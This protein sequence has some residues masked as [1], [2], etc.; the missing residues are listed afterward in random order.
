MKKQ[1]FCIF[2]LFLIAFTFFSI[3]SS[4]NAQ[5]NSYKISGVVKDESGE[6][7]IG[8]TVN[9]KGTQISAMTD[10]NGNF[11]LTIPQEK[12]LLL[13]SFI[14][15]NP[16]ETKIIPNSSNY[17][18]VLKSNQQQLGE[19]VVTALGIKR[20]ERGLGF[21]TETLS[22]EA[23]TDARSNNWAT[24]L[25]GKVA[26][27]NI[28]SAGGG[29]LGTS[30]ITLRGDKSL[31]QDANGALIVLDG[32]PIGGSATGT[33][34][35]SYGAGSGS[36]IP[37]DFGDAINDINPDDIESITVLKGPSAAALYGS[38]GSNGAIIVTTKS[39]SKN[40]KGIG[41]SFSS[42]FSIDNVLK[43]PDYQ[44]EYGQGVQQKDKNGNW[45]YSYGASEDG[46]NTGS[47]SSAFGPKFDGQMYFQY[48]PTV[49]GQSLERQEWKAYKNNIKDFW[50]TGT[51]VRNSISVDGATDRSSFRISLSHQANKWMMPNT[52]FDRTSFATSYNYKVTN[53]L[54]FSTK[55]NFT[56]RSSDNLPGTG[57]NNQSI[58]YFMIFQNPNIDLSW[59]RPIWKTGSYQLEQIH[60]FSSYIDNPYLIAYEMVNPSDK[61]TLIGSV[62]GTYEF[63]RKFELIARTGLEM[64]HENREQH[65]PYNTANYPKGYYREDDIN[66]MEINTDFLFTYR[67]QLTQDIGF[68]ASAGGNIRKTEYRSKSGRVIGLVTP[69]VYKLSNALGSPL[70]SSTTKKKQVNSLYGSVNLNYGK[71]LFL[72][73]TGRNDWSSTLPVQNNSFF[74]P[75]TSLSGIISDMV[76]LPEQ[77]SFLK[78]RASWAE[79][80]N[81]T[82]PY[83][84][85][86]YYES[87][88]FSG[89]SKMP[90]TLHNA[91]LEPEI[92]RSY[93]A[94]IDFRMF[95]NRLTLDLTGYDNNTK[96]Q[97]IEVPLDPTTGYS[98][99]FINAGKIQN[100]G[101][102][103]L[104]SGIPIENKDFKWK[105]STNWSKNWNKVLELSEDLGD[106]EYQQ[107]ASSGTVYF[108]ARK[109]GSLGDMYGYKLLRNPEG[110]VIYDA[111]RGLPARPTDVEYVGNAYAKWKAGI[112]NEFTIKNF[113]ISFSFDGQYGGLVYSQSHH[114]MTEQ[115]KLQHTLYGRDSEDGMLV[116]DGVIDNGDGTYSPNTIR[117]LVS[118]YYADYYRRANVETNSFDATFIKLRDA[119]IEYN[120]PKSI[121]GKLKINS[122]S[123]AIFGRNIWMWTKEYPLFDPEAA[124]LNSSSIVP[125]VEM[126]Q[127][128]SSRTIG[129]NLNVKF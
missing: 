33:D 2:K 84:T 63:S 111:K 24:A 5:N 16:T 73:I 117:V 18:I 125:G 20:E 71:I 128:P 87:T 8:A 56:N 123:L 79:V 94:G 7:L 3:L 85:S 86:K 81:D 83:R 97:I 31:I 120:F 112:Q 55:I 44:Y 54:R 67:D 88:D 121:T 75:S 104:L 46:I 45:Y 50:R 34:S 12:G 124:A 93:E 13:T 36:D 122:L 78:L 126:G 30:R 76:E 127:L 110:K 68:R 42:S 22:G 57:Y 39:G 118:Q 115:G 23:L 90:T 101:L 47:T 26:G 10:I 119:R 15:Y 11:T 100:K 96:N 60:P 6:M 52:G 102:E 99:A 77:I 29:P 19:V 62:N 41:V 72:D 59:Y 129:I 1:T 53:K 38:R 40:K 14:G 70:L 35:N 106:D 25:S 74:Y 61:N 95:G 92:S 28:L 9:F 116:G 4:T 113:R 103:L 91:D 80:G 82:E 51:D 49:E 32:V 64:S 69:G 109:G 107:V 105:V 17:V 48:D 21:T 108:Y 65:R 114:K 43:W 37:I 66:Y 89:S 27:L 58:A 98:K